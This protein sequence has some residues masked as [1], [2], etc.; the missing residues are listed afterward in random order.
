MILTAIVTVFP[1]T[2]FAAEGVDVKAY[3]VGNVRVVRLTQ[4]G[5]AQRVK[6]NAPFTGFAFDILA[7]MHTNNTV[8]MSVYEWKGTYNSTLLQKPIHSQYYELP[9]EDGTRWVEF[10][11]ALPAGEYLFQVRGDAYGVM[12][13]DSHD[14]SLGY[15]Y[16]NGSDAMA[17]DFALT[18]RF[19]EAVDTPFSLCDPEVEEEKEADSE[20]PADSLHHT[21]AV[22]PDTWVFTDGLGRVSLTNK[23]VGDVRDKTVAMFYWTWHWSFSGANVDSLQV[24]IEKY[25]DAKNDWD[26]ELWN[27]GWESYHWN[28]SIYGYSSGTDPWVLRRQAELMANAGVDTIFTDNTNFDITHKPGYDALYDAWEDAMDDGVNTPKVS[29]MLPFL[30]AGNEVTQLRSLYTDIYQ[31]GDHQDLWFYWDGKPMIMSVDRNLNLDD[32]MESEIAEFFTFREPAGGYGLA[33][34]RQPGGWGWLACYPQVPFY[35]SQEDALAGKVEQITVGI[36]QNLDYRTGALTAMNGYNICGRSYSS[37]YPDRYFVEGDE[38]SKW[39]YNFAEQWEYALGKDP[40]VVFVTGWNEFVVGRW[41]SDGAGLENA[42]PD[43]FN[44]EFSRDIEPTKGDLKDHYY[45]QLVNYVRQFKGAT[46]IPTPTASTTIDMNAGEAQWKNVGPY[47]AA[48]AGNTFDRD[49]KG[50]GSV[51]YT[52]TSGRND[53]IGAQIARDDQYV[54][55]HV[56]CADNITPYTDSLWMNLYI[57]SDQ[58]NQGW[59]TFE[60]VVNKSAASADTLVLEKF[61]ATDDYSKTEKVADVE[62]TVDGRYMT[63]KIPKAD[64]G[65]KGDEFTVNFAWTDNVHDEGDYTT[66]SGDI[67]DFYISGD[68]APGGRFKYSYD[69]SVEDEQ[70]TTPE[71]NTPETDAPTTD[72]PTTDAPATDAPATDA[73][74]TTPAATTAEKGG[75]GSLIVGSVALATLL[76]AGFV[77]R[78]RRED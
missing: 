67:M 11:K 32:E 38:A 47:Y 61:T 3:G 70:P 5:V 59:N 58:K 34:G 1:V 42:F 72:A 26:H 25:P 54:Y 21:N 8:T 24:A 14:I 41:G 63:V 29:F 35:G 78:R 23:D 7:R 56:E 60:Y 51:Y 71:T 4:G 12:C 55:F 22:Q 52:E 62:Y 30:A 17:D 15:A 20:I 69:L 16:N 65:L 76:G 53:I 9:E 74:T 28:E 46:P 10:D 27:S 13:Y 45:Y 50:Y 40:E 57:D 43:Q 33:P 18:I 37:S 31:K 48:Y 73:Q 49:S 6:V 2:A 77:L 36:A 39:G 66:F 75:C 19:T 44:D 68:V 64:L